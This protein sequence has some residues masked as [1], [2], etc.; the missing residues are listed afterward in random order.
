MK[1]DG[2]ESHQ[3]YSSYCAQWRKF[4]E[5]GQ[6]AEKGQGKDDEDVKKKCPHCDRQFNK[7]WDLLQRC[8]RF[9]PKSKEARECS[10]HMRGRKAKPAESSQ[11]AGSANRTRS[12][13]RAA[14]QPHPDTPSAAAARALALAAGVP[15]RRCSRAGP[16]EAVRRQPLARVDPRGRRRFW[17][18]L[19]KRRLGSWT[20][21]IEKAEAV[22]RAEP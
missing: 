17:S 8:L 7:R 9:H 11:R 2:L 3:Q 21:R 1:K 14:A 20:S 19:C 16:G 22:D 15:A 13:E 10:E 12:T 6:K 18:R 5:S 4:Q